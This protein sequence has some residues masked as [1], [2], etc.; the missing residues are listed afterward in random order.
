MK[1]PRKLR[2]ICFNLARI[3]SGI[4]Q[5]SRTST[6]ESTTIEKHIQLS[7]NFDDKNLTKLSDAKKKLRFTSIKRKFYASKSKFLYGLSKLAHCFWSPCMTSVP[8]CSSQCAQLDTVQ[9]SRDCRSRLLATS[10]G[11]RKKVHATQ[12]KLGYVTKFRHYVLSSGSSRWQSRLEWRL[13]S[14]LS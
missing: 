7:W 1:I 3:P 14:S 2:R 11:S 10:H 4:F 5:I 9:F 6:I 12:Q 13:Y 8:D